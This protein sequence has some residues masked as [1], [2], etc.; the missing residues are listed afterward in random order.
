VYERRNQEPFIS[1]K[2]DYVSPSVQ[3]GVESTGEAVK[4]DLDATSGDKSSG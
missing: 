1:S 2:N 4:H 3:A